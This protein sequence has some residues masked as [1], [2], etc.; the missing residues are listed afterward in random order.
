MIKE[1]GVLNLIQTYYTGGYFVKRII[2]IMCII[3]VLLL[4]GCDSNT[5]HWEFYQEQSQI[6]GLYIVDAENPNEY[7]IIQEIPLERSQELINDIKSLDYKTYGWNLHNTHGLCFVI[8]FQNGEYDIISYYE[9][10][11]V[12]WRGPNKDHPQKELSGTISWLKCDKKEFD[13]LIEKYSVD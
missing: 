5:Y 12:V 7:E 13:I 11:H 4:T 10:M 9:P 3:S 1:F 2:I 8:Q 6:V